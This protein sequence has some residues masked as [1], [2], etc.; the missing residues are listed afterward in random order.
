VIFR[1]GQR[2]VEAMSM[3]NDE[4]RSSGVITGGG[5][6]T[7]VD[8]YSGLVRLVGRRAPAGRSQ[9]GSSPSGRA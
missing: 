8:N 7:P 3:F 9:P 2:V 4:P 6:L 5:A 1:Q